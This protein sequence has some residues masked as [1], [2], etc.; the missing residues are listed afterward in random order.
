[1]RTHR[2]NQVNAPEYVFLISDLAGERRFASIV[3]KRLESLGALTHGDRRA[4][5][6]RDLSRFNIDNRYGNEALQTMMSDLMEVETSPLIPPPKDWEGDFFADSRKALV[7]VGLV[8]ENELTKV[9][10]LDKD[11]TNMSQFLNRILG[12]PV[13]LQ[14]AM[15]KYFTDTLDAIVSEAKR[16]GHYDLGILGEVSLHASTV[17]AAGL[18]PSSVAGELPL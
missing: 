2:S 12:I 1:G 7:G 16:A 17:R 14:N 5:E 13:E 18:C 3:A 11:Y 8:N 6:S 10:I 9:Q 15:F 4:G